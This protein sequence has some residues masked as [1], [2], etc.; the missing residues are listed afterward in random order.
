MNG[1]TARTVA[2]LTVVSRPT[3]VEMGNLDFIYLD[4][5]GNSRLFT[6]SEKSSECK[7]LNCPQLR[8]FENNPCKHTNKNTE[9]YT[10]PIILS[11]I[12]LIVRFPLKA[13]STVK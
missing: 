10:S 9:K 11:F 1:Q 7:S 8:H 2:H 4:N 13:V 6:H 5:S 12:M 3:A